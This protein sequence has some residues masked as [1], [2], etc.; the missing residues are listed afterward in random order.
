MPN[1]TILRIVIDAKDTTKKTFDGLGKSMSN[2]DGVASTLATGGL[3]LVTGALAL[4]GTTAT[5]AAKE[6]LSFT[7]DLN[8]VLKDVERQTGH[9]S[10][11]MDDFKSSLTNVYTDARVVNVALEDLAD[12]QII[13]QRTTGETGAELENLT[14]QAVAMGDVFEIDVAESMRTVDALLKNNIAQSGQEALDII[15]AGLQ[16]NLNVADDFLDTLTEYSQD[17]NELGLTGEQALNLLNSGL[18]AGIFNTDKIGDATQEFLTSLKDTAVVDK[19]REINP[20]LA[21]IAVSFNDGKI[22]GVEALQQIQAEIGSMDDSLLRNEAGRTL[23]V[24][25]WDDLGQ[26]ALLA[27]DPINNK[28]GDINGSTA[29]ATQENMNWKDALTQ[30]GREFVVAMEPAAQEILP[31]LYDGIKLA[32]GFMR[33]AQPVFAQFGVDMRDTIGPAMAVVNDSL[34]RIAQALGIAT[35]DTTGMDIAIAALKATLDLIV[36]TIQLV[37]IGFHNTAEAAEYLREQLDAIANFDFGSLSSIQQAAQGLANLTPAGMVSNAGFGF[38]GFADG[39]VVPGPIGSPMMAMVHG[40][41]VISPPGQS[42][43]PMFNI[44]IFANDEEGGRR[45][46]RGFVDELRSRGVMVAA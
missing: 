42:G 3:T 28:L 24:S 29:Q 32:G 5:I 14:A 6:T 16:N 23:F 34:V 21:D 36:A 31:L 1:E 15:T 11:E 30:L 40:G 39:G 43:G 10:E 8:G 25:F 2:L 12:A 27:L 7:D 26:E 18:E 13:V 45:A 37:A 17:F 35:E 38:L 9:T 46:G 33:E 41:E 22:T 44:S 20:A 19:L 4:I